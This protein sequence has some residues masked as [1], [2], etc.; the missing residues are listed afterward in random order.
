MIDDSDVSLDEGE[1]LVLENLDE[2]FDLSGLALQ[3]ELSDHGDRTLVI[4]IDFFGFLKMT[5][6]K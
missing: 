5:F 4:R 1:G 2:G 3:I 6:S